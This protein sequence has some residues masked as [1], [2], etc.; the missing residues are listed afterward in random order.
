M[1]CAIT[2]IISSDAGNRELQNELNIVK[3]GS[4]ETDLALELGEYYCVTSWV[5]NLLMNRR[6]ISQ[7]MTQPPWREFLRETFNIVVWNYIFKSIFQTELYI[8]QEEILWRNFNECKGGISQK[9]YLDNTNRIQQQVYQLQNTYKEV[10]KAQGWRR[11]WTLRRDVHIP[12][13][14]IVSK[15]Y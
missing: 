7:H 1:S 6:S 2:R 12:I 15:S 9:L 10:S 4:L 8:Q 3:I 13:Q 14:R 5:R 11:T